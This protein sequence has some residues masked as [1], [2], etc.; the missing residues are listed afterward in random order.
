MGARIRGNFGDIDPLKKVPVKR[1]KSRVKKGPL[2]G[3]SLI[4]PRNVVEL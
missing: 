2:L 4:L 3:V 1:A